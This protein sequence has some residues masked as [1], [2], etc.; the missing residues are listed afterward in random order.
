MYLIPISNPYPYRRHPVAKHM[1]FHREIDELKKTILTMGTL[2][3][4]R[5]RRACALLDTRDD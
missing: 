1:H 5:L 2:V 3:E 4:D